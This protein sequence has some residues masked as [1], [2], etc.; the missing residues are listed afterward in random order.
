MKSSTGSPAWD[1]QTG[2]E[3]ECGGLYKGLMV[4]IWN[5]SPEPDLSHLAKD[6]VSLWVPRRKRETVWR[7]SSQPLPHY[8]VT[9]K[10]SNLRRPWDPRLSDFCGR[11]VLGG[12]GQ[13][14]L[15]HCRC[16]KS[17]VSGRWCWGQPRLLFSDLPSVLPAYCLLCVPRTHSLSGAG[18]IRT[19]CT[20]LKI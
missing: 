20:S 4:Q 8:H 17:D 13:S 9:S 7:T 14:C 12:R 11:Q 18:E 10:D 5:H 3:S 2:P 19:K 1:Q 15:P 16:I 6:V